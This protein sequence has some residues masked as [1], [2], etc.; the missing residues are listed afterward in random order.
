VKLD[1]IFSKPFESLLY[2]EH[3]VNFPKY[4]TPKSNLITNEEDINQ[5]ASV[6]LIDDEI[7]SICIGGFLEPKYFVLN[8]HER[9]MLTA[10][11]S[12]NYKKVRALK[13]GSARTFFVPEL[14]SY[15]KTHYSG[16][17]S[18]NF[19]KLGR[20][21]IDHVNL[22]KKLISLEPELPNHV[23][24]LPE[25][26][27]VIWDE[28]GCIYRSLNPFPA[29]E[30][31][32]IPVYS[33]FGLDKNNP[34][35]VPLFVQIAREKSISPE[36]FLVYDFVKPLIESWKWFTIN[37]RIKITPHGENVLFGMDSDLSTFKII[38]RDLQIIN[39]SAINNLS[40][41]ERLQMTKTYDFH[42]GFLLLNQILENHSEYINPKRI[43]ER[44]RDI[45]NQ[46]IGND[47]LYSNR[48]YEKGVGQ[49]KKLI[50]LDK[51]PKYR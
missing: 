7:E 14:D 38:H 47:L 50:I 19:R 8:P 35:E 23:A 45:F 44:I 39:Y 16:L 36:D 1:Q 10:K 30:G 46:L 41:E 24:I 33:L 2:C 3:N 22:T 34:N 28:I 37:Q 42:I 5:E 49:D 51:K 48:V 40:F 21:V 15:V 43:S 11:Q 4:L 32:M 9:V 18:S 12:L 6:Y 26:A 13:S 20:D 25:Y 29:F 17:I 31:V 27:G